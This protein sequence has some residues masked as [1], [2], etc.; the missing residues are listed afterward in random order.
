MISPTTYI[1][2]PRK[3]SESANILEPLFKK[4]VNNAG[5]IVVFVTVLCVG[6]VMLFLGD[7][8]SGTACVVLGIC[9]A[10]VAFHRQTIAKLHIRSYDANLDPANAGGD[11]FT[12]NWHP[13]PLDQ[14]SYGGFKFYKVGFVE[15]PIPL[16]V[17]R[18]LC[19]QCE[20][21]EVVAESA[22]VIFPGIVQ[23]RLYCERCGFEKCGQTVKEI[24]QKA[25]EKFIDHAG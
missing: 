6:I 7:F 8:I 22:K 25:H 16:W 3:M 14:F 24:R 17:S 9:G 19:P 11:P 15:S 5:T 18:P 2:I 1:L 20:G 23:V 10:S 21:N 13:K 4:A 12:L